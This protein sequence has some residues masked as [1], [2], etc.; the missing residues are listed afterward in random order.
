M[1]IRPCPE[2]MHPTPRQLENVSADAQVWYYRCDSC[3]H[4]WNI[5]KS[6]PN[7]PPRAVTSRPVQR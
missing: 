1:P 6:D 5:P 4:V 2:C 7:A 3:G